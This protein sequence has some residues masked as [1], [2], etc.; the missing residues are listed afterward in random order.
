[1]KIKAAQYRTVTALAPPHLPCPPLIYQDEYL[2]IVNK[3]AGLLAVP[4]RGADKQDCL[5]S[6]MQVQWPQALVVHRLDQATSGLLVLALSAAVQKSLSALFQERHV[7]KR[8]IATVQGHLQPAT[9]TVDLPLM[10]D[11]PQR[12]RQ[13]V[14]LTS[15]KPSQTH[16]EVLRYNA[17]NGTSLVALHPVTGRTHQLRVHMLALG[18]PIVG[19][20]LYGPLQG[21]APPQRMALHAQRLAFTH[22]VTGQRLAVDC[23]PDQKF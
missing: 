19:D 8:Y 21:A 13:K 10:A 23:E 12:P 2:L 11:W 6:R 5:I 7:S 3:P 4:G 14:D 15:G 1:L 20:T 22:P 9:G 16:W 18:H 17:D